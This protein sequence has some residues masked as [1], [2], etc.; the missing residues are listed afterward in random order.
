MYNDSIHARTS[1]TTPGVKP[2]DMAA[3]DAEQLAE[4]IVLRRKPGKRLIIGLAGPPGS[5]KTTLIRQIL[6]ALPESTTAAAVPV[7]G[8]SLSNAT[9]R[10]LGLETRRGDIETFDAAGFAFFMERLRRRTEDLVF[11]PG[12]DHVI[13]EPIAASIIIPRTTD[14][15]L[16]EGNYFLSG[17]G[18]WPRACAAMNEVWY[19]DT[20][21]VLSPPRPTPRHRAAAKPSPD[22]TTW[23]P[24]IGG[25]N[26]RPVIETRANLVINGRPISGDQ[27]AGST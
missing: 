26:A 23:A 2:P 1:P 27:S 4:R 15:I 25:A 24:D 6:A 10:T 17:L 13:G 16:T 20:P 5:G 7:A 19:L 14:I 9:L 3:A 18:P 8:F 12:F 11:A 22:A 21:Y